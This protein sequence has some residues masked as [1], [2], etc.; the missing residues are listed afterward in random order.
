VRLLLA[1]RLSSVV[2]ETE[3]LRLRPLR[4]D[5]LDD[6][7]APHAMPEVSRFMRPLPRDQA[8]DRLDSC[9]REWQH[10]GHGLLAI[11]SRESGRFLGRA[12]L[13]Y[14]PQFDEIEIGWVLNPAVWGQGYATEAAH[15]WA[16]WRPGRRRCVARIIGAFSRLS[17]DPST[18][19]SIT[20]GA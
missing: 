1:A 11:L 7:V 2:I 20:G 6:V 10:R 16:D 15:A 9:E 14:W 4:M 12:G 8:V 17:D 5:D 19:E 3:R 18:L 13:K